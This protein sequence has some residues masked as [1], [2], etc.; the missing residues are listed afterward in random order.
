[1][2][3]VLQNRQQVFPTG[4][5]ALGIVFGDIGTSPLYAVRQCFFG[6]NSVAASH[7]NVVG[8][9]SLVFWALLVVISAK[10]VLLVMKQNNR[11]E[12]GIMALVALLRPM[13][14]R[15]RHVRIILVPLGLFGAALLF[16]DG[17]ITPAISVL[18]AVEGL[19]AI[20]DNWTEWVLPATV[21][22][23]AALFLLQHRGTTGI[24]RI[25]GPVMLLWFVVIALL[26]IGGIMQNPAVLEALN[27]LHGA[28]FLAQNGLAGYLV[29][30]TV[31]LV[32]TGGEAMYADLGHFG[33][34]PIRGSWFCIVL[35][36][37]VLNYFGQ[38]AL[39]LRHPYEAAHPF[40][41][42]APPDLRIAL[43]VLATTATIIASQAVISATYSLTS[44]AM[45]L[46]VLPRMRV[47]HTSTDQRGQIYIPLVNWLLMFATLALVVTFNSSSD[48]GA[49]YGLA[50]SLDMAITTVLAALIAWRYSDRP[51]TALAFFAVFLVVDCAFLGAN[52]FKFVDGGWY[53]IL[54]GVVVFLTMT[55]WR[56]GRQALNRRT[57]D[58]R[59]S[60]RAFVAEHLTNGVHRIPGTAVFLTPETE[61][62]PLV[63]VH[64]LSHHHVLHKNV[65][66][67]TVVTED[68]PHVPASDRFDLRDQA[69]GCYRLILR[70]GY[71]Q[72]P[73]VP[74]ALRL[75][76]HLGLPIDLGETTYYLGRETPVPTQRGLGMSRWRERLF[77]FLERNALRETA[78]FGIP[79]ERV[80]ELGMQVEV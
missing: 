47:I 40:Y 27:P 60:F 68:M 12:G 18:S 49:A 23:L 59:L 70:Y 29:L 78:F 14:K 22:I 4:L 72:S 30:G 76:E 35:P 19:S 7:S 33:L 79:S 61:E 42:L 39:I 15:F 1:M 67:L 21:V 62:V 71:M 31:F 34:G 48:L 16:G 64:H 50:V 66:L 26:G 9:L 63:L 45:Q 24:G 6:V 10:Y 17:S 53:P 73:N 54:V 20:N 11:G 75:C 8:V 3:T 69:H 77:A 65:I 36:A 25:F 37:L 5:V 28:G 56:Q 41:H 55:S 74:V 52:L 44:Q 46:G 43:V 13:A 32:V 38:G 2:S 58:S 80:V 57:D 51:R